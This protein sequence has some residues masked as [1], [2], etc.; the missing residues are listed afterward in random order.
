MSL[1]RK[2]VQQGVRVAIPEVSAISEARVFFMAGVLEHWKYD[3]PYLVIERPWRASDA[4]TVR[5]KMAPPFP[6]FCVD[7]FPLADVSLYQSV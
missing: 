6:S 1:E 2:D 3:L 4:D 5:L 7:S